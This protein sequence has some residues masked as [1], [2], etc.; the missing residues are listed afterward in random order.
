MD[1]AALW[2]TAT[3]ETGPL[4]ARS[5]GRIEQEAAANAMGMNASL[6]HKRAALRLFTLDCPAPFVNRGYFRKT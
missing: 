5:S 6:R 3:G 4:G 2:L 1:P